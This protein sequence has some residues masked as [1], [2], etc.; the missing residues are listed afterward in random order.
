MIFMEGEGTCRL[1]G[2][3]N[4]T[5]RVLPGMQIL[6]KWPMYAGEDADKGDSEQDGNR[7]GE[8]EKS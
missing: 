5:S 6:K 3:N 4:S 2:L 7:N 1:E 8:R